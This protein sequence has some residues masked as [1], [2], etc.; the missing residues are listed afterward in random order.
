MRGIF[1]AVL[2]LFVSEVAFAGPPGGDGSGLVLNL[3]LPVYSAL[4]NSDVGPSDDVS[5][6]E[7][8]ASQASSL[9]RLGAPG[10]LTA[11]STFTIKYKDGSTEKFVVL[12]PAASLNA[13]PIPNTQ[14][15][16][17]S[18]DGGSGGTGSGGGGSGSGGGSGGSDTSFSIDWTNGVWGCTGVNN[19]NYQCHFYPN[20][21][22]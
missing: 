11:G 17:G 16:P 21:T 4:S 12:D 20:T 19:S 5:L 14:K 22:G 9:Y 2:L 6:R 1:L 13:A 10:K 8:I 3:S 7:T 15:P 18:D